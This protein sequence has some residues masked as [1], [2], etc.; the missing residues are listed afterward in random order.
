[1]GIYSEYLD[2]QFNFPDLTAE[3]KQQLHRISQLRGR[4][5]LAFA[6][7]LNKGEAPISLNYSDLLPINDQLAN[8]KGAALDLILETPGGSG[9]AAEDIV[10]VLRQKYQNLAVI[11]PGW[12]KSGG[13]C[14][15]TLQSS[16]LAHAWAIDQAG[17]F[18]HHAAPD[19]RL[20]KEC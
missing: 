7:D 6:A 11:V 19:H 18:C 12:A 3:R 5:I 9:E 16:S 4:D 1:V 2:R 8:L 13:D 10:R 15:R 14:C 17:G 20:F